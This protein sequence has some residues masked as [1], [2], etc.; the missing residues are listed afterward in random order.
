MLIPSWATQTS[1]RKKVPQASK[2]VK[3]TTTPIVRIETKPQSKAPQHVCRRPSADPSW[4]RGCYFNFSE[5]L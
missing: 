1:R 4:F 3:D 5:T 2:R